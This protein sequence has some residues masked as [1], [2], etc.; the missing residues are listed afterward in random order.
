MA[1][2]VRAKRSFWAGLLLCGAVAGLACSDDG[3]DG[4][5]GAPGPAGPAGP[6]GSE[7]PPGDSGGF[8]PD[9]ALEAC[10]GCHGDNSAVPVGDITN[11]LDAHHIDTDP[12][13][14]ATAS[15]YR[16]LHVQ[17]DSVDV[18]RTVDADSL[19]I[20]FTATDEN[21]SFITNLFASDGRFTITRLR[22]GAAPGDATFWE[23]FLTDSGNQPSSERF[24]S[25]TFETNTPSAGRYRYVS[26]FDPATA[27][28][29]TAQIA[30][31]DT[32][33]VALQISGS[34]LPAGNGWCDFDADLSAPN[35]NCNSATRT[36][37]IVQTGTCN[38][39]H[40]ATSD[41]KLAEHGGGR[42]DV[43]YCVTCHNPSLVDADT[44]N[45]VDFTVLI[46]KIHY[47]A[48]LANGYQIGS[49]DFSTVNFTKDIDDCT[50]C[51]T[52]G[53]SN[54]NNWNTVPTMQACGTC[55]DT[56][57][58]ATGANHGSG[59]VQT[60]N[61]FCTGCHPSNGAHPPPGGIP[62]PIQAV[63]LGVARRTE[64]ALYAGGANGF[65]IDNL[66]FASSSD[67]LTVDYHVTRNGSKMLLES[68]PQWTATNGA[69]ALALKVGWNTEPDYTN[70]T[71]G[72]NPAQPIS[73]NALD[74]G[75]AVTALGGGNYRAAVTL[76]GTASESVG[77]SLEGHPA[78]DL[79][80]D[81]T[82]SDR[83]AVKNA[84]SFFS[85][86]SGRAMV[87]IPRRD[88]VDVNQCQD[89]HDEA[90]NGLS[91]HGSNRTGTTQA[92]V[93]CHNPD[94]T[95]VNRRPAPP[96]ITA[97]GKEEEMID[98][99]RLVHM[100]HSGAELES[101]LVVY[102]FNGS[103]NDFSHVHFIGN[104]QNCETCHVPGSYSTE[105]AFATLPTTIDTAADRSD[106]TDDLNISPTA[107]VCSG[108]HDSEAA[109]THMKLH[110]A[111]FH[112]LDV[113]IN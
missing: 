13:G 102:G 104:R 78:A 91:A 5:P 82:Y 60:T 67:T 41:T 95:D 94:A 88:V 33:R 93:L 85:V 27:P 10:V 2:G 89:C 49:D 65:G 19:I 81:G 44:G 108:C 18:S 34:D 86:A 61:Q 112:A 35:T 83:I 64:G 42:T 24:S 97:D 47:G 7:G 111:S 70:E 55:H 76:P 56:V 14:P 71:S 84:V 92:C 80:A 73:V 45:S 99:K 11:V 105:K 109:L 6:P 79:D 12:R 1:R 107:S 17:V 62:Q 72:S 77:V 96:A 16:Q 26:Q 101:P 38:G 74:L 29:G 63:H 9:V 21:G 28:T 103:V 69:S 53:G 50:V 23:S 90:G 87:T 58:F 39:C 75:G 40:G 32:L 15:G 37:D 22:P 59:G 20:H 51:H 54:V 113:D 52:G 106:S 66:S 4:A 57:N 30:S 100:I 46:H 48:S 36:R 8:D 3:D 98:F 31:G 43:E 25:G 110:G 68:A